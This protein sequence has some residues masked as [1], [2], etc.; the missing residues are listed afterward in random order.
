MIFELR[1]MSLQLLTN[2]VVIA[3]VDCV[4]FGVMNTMSVEEV[5]DWLIGSGFS[6]EVASAFIGKTLEPAEFIITTPL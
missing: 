1:P 4:N 6:S 5:G 2:R 3:V